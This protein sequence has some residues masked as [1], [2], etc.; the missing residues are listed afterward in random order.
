MQEFTNTVA[1]SYVSASQMIGRDKVPIPKEG[2]DWSDFY[3]AAGRPD[4]PNG[5]EFKPPAGCGTP[6]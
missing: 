2:E 4:D 1:K 5:Y 6:R 3:K